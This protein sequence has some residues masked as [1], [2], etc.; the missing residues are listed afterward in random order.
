MLP[1]LGSIPF[2][3]TAHDE[4]NWSMTSGVQWNVN[5]H[6]VVTAEAGFANRT[7]AI[8]GITYRF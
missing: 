1:P 2:S 5:R 6:W 8:V 4:H 7:Q 3:A